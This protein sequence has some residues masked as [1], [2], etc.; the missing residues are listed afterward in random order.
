MTSDYEERL[1]AFIQKQIGE[2]R[3]AYWV[4]PLVEQGEESELTSVEAQTEMLKKRFGSA[5]AMIHGKMDA[6]EKDAVMTAFACGKYKILVATTVIEVGINVPNAALMIIKDADRFGLSQLHQLRGRVGR[7][8]ARSYCVLVS[9]TRADSAKKRMRFF[10]STTDGF[11]IAAEDLAT[12]GPGDLIGARQSGEDAAHLIARSC[13]MRQVETAQRAAGYI[14]EKDPALSLPEH[15]R[16]HELVMEKFA[17]N[18]DI[19][20]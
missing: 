12:R 1:Y 2:G 20:S 3:Q 8:S 10:T 7:G 18:G 11:K 16:L 6:K 5:V 9:D 15:R 17:Q 13:D 19:F 4:C 14:L